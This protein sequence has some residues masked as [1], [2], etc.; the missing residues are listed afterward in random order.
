MMFNRVVFLSIVAAIGVISGTLCAPAL[1]FIADHFAAQFSSIQ[2]TISLFLLGN[3]LG[4]FF[5]GPLSDQIGQRTVLLGGLFL[6]LIASCGCATADRMSILLTARFF[7]GMGSAVGPVLA[8]AIASSSFSPEKAAQVQSYGAAGVGVASLLA[9]LSSGFLSRISWR[10]NFWLAASL[11]VVLLLWA[12]GT[13]NKTSPSDTRRFSL[14]QIFPQL[15][16]VF[17]NPSFFGFALCHSITYGLMY[18][19]IAQFPFLLSDLFHEDDPAQVGI[20]SAYMIACYLLGAFTASRL[21]LRWESSRLIGIGIALQLISGLGLVFPFFPL[22]L[23][24]AL[25]VFNFSIGVIL[26]LTSASALAPFVGQAMVG[27]ASSSLGLSYRLLGAL[28][29]ILIAQVPLFGG[30][31]LG[32]SISLFSLGSLLIFK[33]IDSVRAVQNI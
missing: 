27:T 9:I 16:Q 26:P 17:T 30:K 3:A 15:K 24:P 13:L 11:G 33:R 18:S 31:A 4:Q 12:Y 7:Q 2:F 1:P 20:Y 14:K 25:F 29:S 10:G 6:Y 21:V 22:S 28:L 32:F 8:R 23:F 19:Y 5:S